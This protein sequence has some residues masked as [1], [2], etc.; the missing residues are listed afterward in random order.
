MSVPGGPGLREARKNLGARL[1]SCFVHA[2]P[3]ADIGSRPLTGSGTPVGRANLWADRT[4]R[5]YSLQLHV[6]SP[7]NWRSRIVTNVV[8]RRRQ[9]QQSTLAPKRGILLAAY[10]CCRSAHLVAK[11]AL[12]PK[13]L[14]RSTSRH[15]RQAVIDT[16]LSLPT[17]FP[18]GLAYS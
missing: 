14:Y 9:Q 11:Q 6:P 2:E 15:R 8:N 3:T 12:T 5:M 10:P 17:D 13:R 18:V 7:V 16:F 1:T 4:E